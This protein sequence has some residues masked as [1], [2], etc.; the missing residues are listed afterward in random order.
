MSDSPRPRSSLTGA[1]IT[2]VLDSATLESLL[3]IAGGDVNFLESVFSVFFETTPQQ[4]GTMKELLSELKWEELRR[5][6]HTLRGS[7]ATL[8]APGFVK[9]CQA[10]EE[11]CKEKAED[12]ATLAIT[13]LEIEF[14]LID[15]EL[16][17]FKSRS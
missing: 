2:P 10:L 6:S 13:A 16:Q 14:Q 1:P 12:A 9:V 17:S 4:L 15:S 3:A 5:L 8:G 11:A 7:C